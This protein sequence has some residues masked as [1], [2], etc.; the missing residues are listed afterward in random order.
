MGFDNRAADR[1]AHA[2]GLRRVEGFKETRQ[3]LWAQPVAGIPH[4][5][6]HFLRLDTHGAD[7]QLAVVVLNAT[8]ASCHEFDAKGFTPYLPALVRHPVVLDQD[9]SSLINLTLNGSSPLVAK[10][11]PDAYRMPQ[12][13]QQLSDQD[14]A[15]VITLIRKWLGQWDDGSHCRASR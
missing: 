14:I 7:V 5:D 13:R 10:G 3:A 9:P 15:D 8:C 11:T 6:A 2:V 4:W 12:F 1:E